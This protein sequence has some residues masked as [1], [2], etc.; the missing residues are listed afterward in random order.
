MGRQ[1][2][3][4]WTEFKPLKGM[5]AG[6]A[7]YQFERMKKQPEIASCYILDIDGVPCLTKRIDGKR[8][9]ELTDGSICEAIEHKDVIE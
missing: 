4:Y 2:Y 8:I 9:V 6:T 7:K 1:K 3:R 5:I